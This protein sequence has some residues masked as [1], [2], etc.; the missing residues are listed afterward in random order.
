MPTMQLCW[1][2]C[3]AMEPKTAGAGAALFAWARHVLLIALLC[4]WGAGEAG[5]QSNVYFGISATAIT[6]AIGPFPSYSCGNLSTLTQL[7]AVCT[8]SG[9]PPS[10][11]VPACTEYML[12]PNDAYFCALSG[13][14][15]AGTYTFT[16]TGS[17]DGVPPESTTGVLTVTG[18]NTVTT[19]TAATDTPAYGTNAVVTVSVLGSPGVIPAG[20]VN[21]DRKD[22]ATGSLVDSRRLTLDSAGK[23][24]YVFDSGT[25]ATN[26]EQVYSYL[27]DGTNEP[28]TTTLITS[29]QRI[30]PTLSVSLTPSNPAPG[31]PFTYSLSISS[32]VATP[33]GTV[34]FGIG[35]F[36]IGT[37]LGQG[38]LDANGRFSGTA[39][40][41]AGITRLRLEYD[42]D[43]NF[44]AANS[45]LSVNLTVGSTLSTTTLTASKPSLQINEAVTLT[46]TV[47]P[48]SATGSVA[49][50]D[51]ATALCAGAPVTNGIATCATALAAN[52]TRSLTAKYFGNMDYAS[53]TGILSI[54]VQGRQAQSITFNRPADAPLGSGAVT[55]TA[56]A[57]S[58]LAVT[59]AS[60]TS[61]VCTVAGSTVTLVGAGLCAI[62]ASQ[63][64]DSQWL[65]A[66]DVVQSFNVGKAGQTITFTPPT[67]IVFRVGATVALNATASSGL[68]VTFTSTTVAVCSVS[69]STAT[70]AAIGTC[71]IRAAQIGNATYSAA[72]EVTVS[73]GV[74]APP[75]VTAAG[76]VTPKTF[77]RP[78]EILT[79]V[80]TLTN[81]GGITAT[82]LRI[83]EA[84]MPNL[85]CAGTTIAAGGQLRCQGTTVTTAADLVAGG[86]NISPAL[87]YTYAEAVP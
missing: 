5:A 36:S 66:P 37:M 51:G 43:S 87:T 35:R 60:T 69:G 86:V 3:G 47:T 29:F 34:R 50:S 68:A 54:D 24:T 65:A 33:T 76:E 28:S 83:N 4:V 18:P 80:I 9:L 70:I 10:V 7:N 77:V 17:A 62:T 72:S 59:F 14:I 49:F 21:V 12:R 20:Q 67:G 48:A 45:S 71:T 84:R 27:G 19:A 63:A 40:L 38:A 73:F 32:A 81:T 26:F 1:G 15:P 64:G 57:S 8:L 11:T 74:A 22:L 41:P 16:I 79:F 23:A 55:L 56:N 39:S 85:A 25:R 82:G 2:I 42:G 78:G 53:S 52:G 31:E 13:T 44:T 61:G 58:N 6:S 46:A 75:R 30:A